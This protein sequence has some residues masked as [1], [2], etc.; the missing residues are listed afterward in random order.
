MESKG[1]FV[2]AVHKRL[3]RKGRK[4]QID[5]P[6]RNFNTSSKLRPNSLA[7]NNRNNVDV[8]RES[9]RNSTRR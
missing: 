6:E 5:L 2:I 8:A 3:I 9:L 1:S 7:N 4:E